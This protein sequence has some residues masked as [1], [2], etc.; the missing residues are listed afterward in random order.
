VRIHL[1]VAILAM[2]VSV[3]GSNTAIAAGP[4]YSTGFAT[5]HMGKVIGGNGGG[6]F[7][8]RCPAGEN[9]LAGLE[10]TTDER[11]STV[12]LICGTRQG[13]A[14]VSPVRVG[15]DQG[16]VSGNRTSAICPI[17][18]TVNDISV[19]ADGNSGGIIG[20]WSISLRCGNAHGQ[21]GIGNP[22]YITLAGFQQE[23]GLMSGPT[24]T[25]GEDECPPTYVAKGVW[26]RSGLFIDAIGLICDWVPADPPPPPPVHVAANAGEPI[27]ITGRVAGQ[28]PGPGPPPSLFSNSWRVTPNQGGPFTLDLMLVNGTAATGGNMGGAIVASDNPSDK[29]DMHGRQIDVTHAQLTFT[30][31]ANNRSG[32]IDLTVTGDGSTF[33]GLGQTAD[34]KALTWQGTKTDP[35]PPAAH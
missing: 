16:T 11:V 5:E 35:P 26:G 4:T 14:L 27:K 30:Q 18:G 24:E 9:Y 7:Q 34:G 25:Y 2:I 31:P 17:G 3:C 29:G 10:V 1:S 19:G 23:G 21:L 6:Q 32:V 12:K 28:A 13:E 33:T 20:V 8:L 15:P 22:T